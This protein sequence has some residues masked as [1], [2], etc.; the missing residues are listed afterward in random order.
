MKKTKRYLAL[1]TA[2]FLA[3][4][5]M[6]A[7][8][9]TAVAADTTYTITVNPLKTGTHEYNAYQ[10]FKGE[11][12]GTGAEADSVAGTPADPYIL[13]DIQW[14]DNI[15]GATFLSAL[16]TNN[17][18]L[19]DDDNDPE[20]A[21]VNAFA[22][23]TD[24]AGVAA[25]LEEYADDSEFAI[26]FAKFAGANLTGAAKATDNSANYELGGLAAG[27]YLV[28][29]AAG[30]TDT[31]PRT[32]NLLKVAGNVSVTTKEDLPTLSKV[33]VGGLDSGKANT[34][35]VGDI[36]DYEI[37]SFVPNMKGYEK[38]FFVVND[39]MEAGLTFNPSSVSIKIMDDTTVVKTLS[40]T[41]D[42]DV[43]T[44][45]AADG[46]S[47][48]IV[49]N[50]FIQY[51]TAA[52]IGKDIVIDYNATV[53]NSATTGTSVESAN[54]NTANLTYSNNPNVT[55]SGKSNEYPDEP[56]PPTPGEPGDPVG[57]TTND[58]TYTYLTELQIEK[59]D[60]DDPSIKLS[61]AK[62]QLTGT[63]LNSVLHEGGLYVKNNAASP[64]YYLLTNGTY[65]STAPESASP[66][67][68]GYASADKYAYTLTSS[69]TG[70]ENKVNAFGTSDTNGLITF[71]KLG[72]GTYTILETK[73]PEGGYNKLSSPISVTIIG[74][75]S[76]NGCTW[77]YQKGSDAATNSNK[78]VVENAKGST[79]PSTGGI[80]TKLFYLFGGLLVAGSVIFLVTK[81]RMNTREN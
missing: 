77:S 11:L 40:S 37:T 18:F 60:K 12:S 51:N 25:V 58:T 27:Y 48:Q 28:V 21:M 44:G 80:G 69:L 22:S 4:T 5:P 17:A 38:Y 78:I 65:T 61:G 41:E 7:T 45:D 20:T 6:A 19:I 76:R 56:K 70:T 46:Y 53:N 72:A 16:K 32:L 42:F 55:S 43:Q 74:S 71:G 63:S 30:I 2:G 68:A 49:F 81:R 47:F 23:A 1:M 31:N 54:T 62:F 34:A 14:G 26:A 57:N 50:N 59:V 10:I 3:I 13:S 29:D 33:I 24:A 9:L 73:A 66:L 15:N 75:P 39:T 35:S 8:G 64:A 67:S 36:V 79:L 52:Y